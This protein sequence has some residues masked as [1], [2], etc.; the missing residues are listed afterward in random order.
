[1]S[2]SAKISLLQLILVLAA[3]NAAFAQGFGAEEMPVVR[4]L[5]RSFSIPA[6]VTTDILGVDIGMPRK[7]AYAVMG[8]Y[9]AP[10][11]C[12]AGSGSRVFLS[13]GSVNVAKQYWYQATTKIF[14]L[15][16]DSQSLDVYF[17]PTLI[18]AR[19]AAISRWVSFSKRNVPAA[20]FELSL[21]GKYGAPSTKIAGKGGAGSPDLYVWLWGPGGKIDL[22]NVTVSSFGTIDEKQALPGKCAAYTAKLAKEFPKA[23]YYKDQIEDPFDGCNVGLTVAATLSAIPGRVESAQFSLVDFRRF[24]EQQ[25]AVKNFLEDELKKRIGSQPASG[26]RL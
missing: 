6:T 14:E 19:I 25:Q 9:T 13:M 3:V 11:G 8:R 26:P 10:Y 17:T 16:G 12:C 7:D 1:M 2:A 21:V 24:T 5:P 15:D 18:G 4:D 23:Q 22:S 20:Q